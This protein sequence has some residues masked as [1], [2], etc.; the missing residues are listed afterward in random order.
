MTCQGDGAPTDAIAQVPITG[1]PEA[2]NTQLKIDDLI[3]SDRLGTDGVVGSPEPISGG[4]VFYIR[5][6]TGMAALDD[7][8]ANIIN[9]VAPATALVA[10]RLMKFTI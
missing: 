6:T 5:L 8:G 3:Y 2:V 7:R 10:L 4:I 9:S 1:D